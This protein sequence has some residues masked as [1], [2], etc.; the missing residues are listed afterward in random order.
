MNSLRSIADQFYHAFY[1]KRWRG[2][3]DYAISG[4][5]LSDAYEVQRLVAE[6]RAQSGERV[7]GYKV[8][9]TS[10]A[11]QTQFGLKEPI[12]GRLF[13]P[14]VQEEGIRLDWS[15]YAN[16]AIEPEMVIRIGRDL[17]GS[18][19]ADEE[20]ID[21]IEYVSPGIELHNYTFWNGKPTL[22]EL[23]CSGGIH[24]G[25][26]IG[27][28]KVSPRNLSFR[29]ELFSVYMD[30]VSITSA[31]AS[32]IMGG[33]L[34]SLRWLAGFLSKRG[35]CLKE[36]SWVIPGS[37]TELVEINRDTELKVTIERVGEVVAQFQ[38]EQASAPAFLG[39]K[40]RFL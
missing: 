9:C 27:K 7:V 3:N 39:K 4:L 13:A 38:S 25:V 1:E 17:S 16:C 20:L 28:N 32:E 29:N 5:T 11:I 31:S 30:N 23:I 19:I 36:G 26:V 40:P 21:A 24:A 37:P 12:C 8:G 22:Q 34:H 14:Y 18:D 15:S 35:D 6:R 33:P 2:D 10:A